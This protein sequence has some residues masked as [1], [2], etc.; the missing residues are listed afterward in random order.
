MNSILTVSATLLQLYALYTIGTIYSIA[1]SS[2][3]TVYNLLCLLHKQ[4]ASDN[5]IY[6]LLIISY[7][8]LIIINLFTY[9]NIHDIAAQPTTHRDFIHVFVMCIVCIVSNYIS[10][11][12]HNYN[13]KYS[14]QFEPYTIHT[15]GMHTIISFAVYCIST[16]YY[17][18]TASVLVELDTIDQLSTIEVVIGIMVIS[19][20]WQCNI[21]YVNR[22]ID[23]QLSNKHNRIDTISLPSYIEFILLMMSCIV[24][25]SMRGESEFHITLLLP[26]IIVTYA[27]YILNYSNNNLTLLAHV[28]YTTSH[29]SSTHTGTALDINMLRAFILNDP[30][31]VRIAIFLFI[32]FLFMFVELIY[33]YISNSLGLISDAGHMLFDCAALAI[34]L[35]ASF[36]SQL[37]PNSQYTY[38]YG[39]YETLSGF[40]NGIFLLLIG[41]FVFV[42]A[43][44]RLLNPPDISGT[45]LIYVAAAGFGVNLIGLIFFHSDHSHGAGTSDSSHGHSHSNHNIDGIFL[46]VLA[47]A[48]GSIGVILSSFLVQTFGWTS[49][50]AICSM[51]IS[52]MIVLSVIPLIKSTSAILLQHI[53]HNTHVVSNDALQQI[54][55]IPYVNSVIKMQHWRLSE[56][57]AVC[58]IHINV[59]DQ[60][61]NQPVILHINSILSNDHSGIKFDNVVVEVHNDHTTF[62]QQS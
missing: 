34:G 28:D 36:I 56:G 5:A 3:F 17:H 18:T 6:A 24:I 35:Y 33:G 51:C 38:G 53:P 29:L 8:I 20:L 62:N 59:S 9:N 44:E 19:I 13:A 45:G 11:L 50:D 25:N 40:I 49:A 26:I 27:L 43:V 61:H 41:Y 46:H 55:K 21:Y 32:N 22:Y 57:Y 39:R 4:R 2:V 37:K 16:I 7:T 14:K 10:A 47:D 15:Y 48:L 60:S 42:E 1:L 31:S 54:N 58:T 12:Q 30:T 23:S 52:A